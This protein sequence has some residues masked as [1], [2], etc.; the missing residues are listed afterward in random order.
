M[1]S[2]IV[3]NATNAATRFNLGVK[4][5]AKL[6]ENGPKTLHEAAKLYAE[7]EALVANSSADGK[8]SKTP[9]PTSPQSW[10]PESSVICS[11]S[12]SERSSD[13]M[14]AGS[15]AMRWLTGPLRSG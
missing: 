4:I 9:K 14:S 10:G 11:G 13:C 5:D 12:S 3:I 2:V 15:F 1:S 7:V 8:P 6:L